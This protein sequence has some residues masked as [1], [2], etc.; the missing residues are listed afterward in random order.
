MKRLRLGNPALA[1][2]LLGMMGGLVPC[3]DSAP[4]HS[5][6]TRK[7]CVRRIGHLCMRLTL[8]AVT[9]LAFAL[10]KGSDEPPTGINRNQHHL[11][12]AIYGALEP[13]SLQV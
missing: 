13:L 11:H 5:R 8:A 3:A 9:I 1:A 7:P 2:A 10:P 4:I 6:A 12:I